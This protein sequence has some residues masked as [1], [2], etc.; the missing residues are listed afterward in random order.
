M[1]ADP[2][3][4]AGLSVGAPGAGPYV[5]I[6]AAGSGWI[7]RV[8][9]RAGEMHE[10]P[11]APAL[12]PQQREDV[13]FLA[14]SLLEP[15]G[16]PVE[17]RPAPPPPPAAPRPRTPPV[18][19]KP[20]EAAPEPP[21]VEP[22]AP[23]PPPVEP[24]PPEPAP[25]PPPPP[26]PRLQ[27]RLGGAVELRPFG[28]VTG[29]AWAELQLVGGPL[30]PTLGGAWAGPSRLATIEADARHQAADAWL[31]LVY[32]ADAPARFDV[33]ITAGL[34]VRPFTQRGESRG[35]AYVPVVTTRVEVPV[36]ATPWLQVEPGVQ[37]AIDTVEV[38]VRTP[39][40]ENVRVGDW[41]LRVGVAL[42]PLRAKKVTEP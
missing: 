26:A 25:A 31:G 18:E 5:E 6:V 40:G 2:L 3:A 35:T 20:E 16:V 19:P 32:A 12:T 8:R 42:R 23:E 37:L 9:D 39:D 15:M 34:S 38:D 24:A 4:L 22:A 33:G 1:W 29:V 10:A 7:V 21:P 30:R 13:A 36:R 28:T 11:V 17:A 27:G 14:A 41:S